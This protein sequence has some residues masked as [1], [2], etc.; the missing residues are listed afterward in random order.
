MNDASLSALVRRIFAFAVSEW[1]K[2]HDRPPLRSRSQVTEN[3][4]VMA[5]SLNGRA[6]AQFC[7]RMRQPRRVPFGARLAV[8]AMFIVSA[9]G[10]AAA[11]QAR[12]GGHARPY[13]LDGELTRR[14]NSRDPR[15]TT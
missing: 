15:G 8:L 7:V 6:I 4:A 5:D 3:E 11:S 10:V 1:N 13:K 2:R 9:S 14:A 12:R